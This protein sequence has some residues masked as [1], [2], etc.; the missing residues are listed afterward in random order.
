MTHE[1]RGVI[2]QPLEAD[3]MDPA[4]TGFYQAH[5][6]GHPELHGVWA[7]GIRNT[8]MLAQT[9][10]SQ[11]PAM[12]E[13]LSDREFWELVKALAEEQLR[14]VVLYKHP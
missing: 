6:L 13:P 7:K 4:R 10:V 8:A 5:I 14:K 12:R 3:R 1:M 2:L 9:Q 11:L